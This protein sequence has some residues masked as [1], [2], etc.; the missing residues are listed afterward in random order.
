MTIPTAQ[1]RKQAGAGGRVSYRVRSWSAEGLGAES[2][3]REASHEDRTRV[4][5][6]ARG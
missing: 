2:T 3:A 6:Q 5:L 4:L 1:A